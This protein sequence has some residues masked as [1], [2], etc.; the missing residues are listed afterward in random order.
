MMKEQLG[1]FE[2]GQRRSQHFAK[3]RALRQRILGGGPTRSG[4]TARAVNPFDLP[5]R[6]PTPARPPYWRLH[7][8]SRV[9]R[10]LYTMHADLDVNPLQIVQAVCQLSYLTASTLLGRDQSKRVS[11]PRQV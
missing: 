10:R 7:A 3:N 8:E 6:L 9:R 2:E 4:T 1:I 11:L 5:C